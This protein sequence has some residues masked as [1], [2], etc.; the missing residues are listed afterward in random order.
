MIIH[1]LFFSVLLQ[2]LLGDVIFVHHF[3]SV[4]VFV[5]NLILYISVWWL[6]AIAASQIHAGHWLTVAQGDN[7]AGRDWRMIL[8]RFDSLVSST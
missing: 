2:F 6:I 4:Y 3:V 5:W 1:L 8:T 7:S